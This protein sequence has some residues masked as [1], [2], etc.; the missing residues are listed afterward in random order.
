MKPMW[1]RRLL[2]VSIAIVAVAVA[3]PF[4]PQGIA[5]YGVVAVATLIGLLGGNF[6]ADYL[7][8]RRHRSLS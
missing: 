2:S 5:F 4:E 6:S 3:A 7:E 8:A 1:E